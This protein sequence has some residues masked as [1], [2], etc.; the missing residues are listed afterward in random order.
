MY[1]GCR[2]IWM[3]TYVCVC[4]CMYVCHVCMCVCWS[5]YKG[6]SV[7]WSLMES[8]SVLWR[9]TALTHRCTHTHTHTHTRLMSLQIRIDDCDRDAVDVQVLSTVPVMFW[10]VSGGVCVMCVMWCVWC[11]WCVWWC[12]DVTI[13]WCDGCGVYDVMHAKD[14]CFSHFSYWAKGEDCLEVRMIVMYMWCE[15]V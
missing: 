1:V 12:D 14:E 2:R 15:C 5:H 9:Q 10:C 3:Y 8:S 4:T 13:W 6:V 11:V 7:I